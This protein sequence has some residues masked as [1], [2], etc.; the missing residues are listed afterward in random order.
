MAAIRI[1]ARGQSVVLAALLW[2][3]TYSHAAADAAS[4]GRSGPP[5]GLGSAYL[6]GFVLG[7]LMYL[8]GLALGI[9]KAHLAEQEK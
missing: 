5:M 2:A 1:H 8:A 7:G 6:F 3:V 9:R 4:T